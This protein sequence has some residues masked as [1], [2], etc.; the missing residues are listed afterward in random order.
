MS[1]PDVSN[2]LIHFTRGADG[3][4]PYQILA[5]ILLSRQLQGSNRLIRGGHTC[6][7]FT[8]APVTVLKDGM[9]PRIEGSGRYSPFGLMFDKKW[10]FSKGGRPAIYQPD[11]DYGLLPPSLAWRHVVYDP[12]AGTDFTWEREWRICTD[13][14]AFDE[15]EA[16]AVVPTSQWAEELIRAYRVFADEKYEMETAL[17][18]EMVSEGI[19]EQPARNDFRWRVTWIWDGKGMRPL[20]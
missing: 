2:A 17:Y 15:R 10:V 8:E 16:V 5:Q 12:V 18:D 4:E 13:A 3:F 6:V 19:V 7:C 11:A 1:R 20:R 9:H 14:L